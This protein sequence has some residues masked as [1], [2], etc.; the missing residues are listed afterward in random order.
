MTPE[1]TRHPDRIDDLS[2][3][4]GKLR[5]KLRGADDRT[6][7]EVREGLTPRWAFIWADLGLTWAVLAGVVA[8]LV[9]AFG[10]SALWIQVIAGLVG[11]APIGV[12]V[13]RIGLFVHEGAHSNVAPGGANDLVTNLGAGAITMTDVRSYRP[14]HMAHHRH[15]GTTKDTEKT[16]FQRFDVRFVLR[17]ALGIHVL[18]VLRQRSEDTDDVAAGG[19]GVVPVLGALC[20]VTIVIASAV[21]GTWVLAIAWV[22]GVGSVYPTVQSTRQLLEHRVDDA[23][24]SIDYEQVDQ[25]AETRMFDRAVMGPV[26]GGAGFNRHLLHHWDAKVSYTRLKELERWLSSTDAAPLIHERQTTYLGAATT[27]WG[28]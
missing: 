2:S 5:T 20:H 28:R 23:D 25:G 6:Y 1:R 19:L 9:V 8:V 14:I 4:F 26:L 11:A 15:L 3:S 27:L 12:L 21:T 22:V 24:G 18:E 10:T 7:R 13:H 16:Y 17:A